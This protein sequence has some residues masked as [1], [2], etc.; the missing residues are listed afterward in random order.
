MSR[1]GQREAS[2]PNSNADSSRNHRFIESEADLDS[3][4]KQ[5]LPLTQNPPLFYPELVKGG[6]VAQLCSLLSHE[7]LDIAMDA[8]QVIQELT[9]EDVGAEADDL[10]ADEAGG[11]SGGGMAAKT[12]RVMADLIDDLVSLPH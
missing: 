4:L 12:A 9:D 5:L 3:A 11:S 2:G 6:T 7:N 10:A 8:I 1:Q